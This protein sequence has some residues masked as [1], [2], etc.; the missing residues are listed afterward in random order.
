MNGV[1]FDEGC[2]R[3][4]TLYGCR[5]PLLRKHLELR[6]QISVVMTWGFVEQVPGMNE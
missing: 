1:T 4:E 3:D 6:M 2:L 5:Q